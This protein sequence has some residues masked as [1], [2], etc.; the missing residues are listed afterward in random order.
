MQL[1]I[2]AGL[3][4]GG[5]S[6]TDCG[7][8]G[9]TS[10]VVCVSLQLASWF[11]ARFALSTRLFFS[12]WSC[13]VFCPR[14]PLKICD[15][16]KVNYYREE[17]HIPPDDQRRLAQNVPDIL[18]TASSWKSLLFHSYGIL[19]GDP[20]CADGIHFPGWWKRSL[21]SLVT[22]SDSSKSSSCVRRTLELIF[23]RL[24]PKNTAQ[25]FIFNIAGIAIVKRDKIQ[26]GKRLYYSTIAQKEEFEFNLCHLF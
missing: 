24:S 21:P 16:L 26:R 14:L 4:V 5:R 15:S 17:A 3:R 9:N 22:P 2:L 12:F 7:P 1:C 18:N 11:G 13:D 25:T 6:V 20:W 8:F 19:A 10:A 23:S